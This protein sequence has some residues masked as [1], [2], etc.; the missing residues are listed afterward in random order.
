MRTKDAPSAEIEITPAMIAAG[1]DELACRYVDIRDAVPGADEEVV[2]AILR[3]V[4]RPSEAAAKARI[5]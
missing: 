4:L 1:M 2:E 5:P 3:R